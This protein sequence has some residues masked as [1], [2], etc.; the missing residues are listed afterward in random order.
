M[1]VIYFSGAD[2]LYWTVTSV[3]NRRTSKTGWLL[4]KWF[5]TELTFVDHQCV[6]MEYKK[7]LRNVATTSDG[8][9]L[10]LRTMNSLDIYQID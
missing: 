4:S 3:I 2:D 8:H 6:C 10:I 9:Y 1:R 5:N 7:E